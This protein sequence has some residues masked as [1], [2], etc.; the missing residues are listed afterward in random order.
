MPGENGSDIQIPSVSQIACH[1]CGRLTDVSGCK[2]FTTTRCSHCKASIPVPGK[3]GNFVLL[4]ILSRD[5]VS[6]TYQAHD[7]L[8]GRQV[9]VRVLE[10]Q[11]AANR[12][13]P[14]PRRP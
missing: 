7:D 2:A 4:R 3:L 10:P 11:L 6:T 12:R 13:G 14:R 9:A 8:L 1:S 5:K